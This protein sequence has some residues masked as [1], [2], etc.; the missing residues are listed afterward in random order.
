MNQTPATEAAPRP[1]FID[2][3]EVAKMIRKHLKKNFA[4]VKF[5]V[6]ISRYAGGS[7]INVNWTDGPT[8][9]EVKKVTGPFQGNRFDG[10]IDLEYHASQW[11]C[12]EHGARVAEVYGHGNGLDGIGVSRCCAK[13]EHVNMLAGYIFE[14]RELSDE[15]LAELAVRVRKES[16][17]PAE[18][19][20]LDVVPET[21]I[22]AYG[23]TRVR[24]AA[25]RLSQGITR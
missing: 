10:M 9:A 4:G 3:A 17:M 19:D 14:R 18:G 25:W 22:H 20:L 7:S 5:S 16:G 23:W 21:S 12:D 6:R 13:A 24:E 11:Y 2:T 1:R 15:F 8:E